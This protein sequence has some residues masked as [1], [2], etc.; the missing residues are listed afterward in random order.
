MPTTN[1]GSKLSDETLGQLQGAMLEALLTSSPLPG[2][3]RMLNLP[4]LPLVLGQPDVVVSS[5]NLGGPV[6]LP[7]LTRPIYIL[8]E[9]AILQR[10]QNQGDFQ[11]LWFQP[12]QSIQ[13]G[14]L[15]TLQIRI[16]QRAPNLPILGLSGVQVTFRQSGTRWQAA[17]ETA[18]FAA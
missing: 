17:E 15:L 14:V 13:D 7:G 3:S 6:R 16:A 8:S 10:A 1:S 18:G 12:P 5:E 11:Y 2:H 9:E 4:D